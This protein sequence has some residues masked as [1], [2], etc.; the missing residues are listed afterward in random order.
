M[1]ALVA[2]DLDR[3]LI[4]SRRALGAEGRTRALRCV[5]VLD[6]APAAFMTEPCADLLARLDRAAVV[7][8]VT[9][10]MHRQYRRVRLPMPPPRFALAANGGVLYVD[11]VPDAGWAAATRRRLAGG[12]PL[13]QVW[14]Y[15][16][17]VC[18]TEF[19]VKLCN[20]DDLF[21][22]A[23][24]RPH[25]LPSGFVDDVTGWAAER[26][27]RT[28]LQGRKFYLVPERLDKGAAVA[29]VAARAGA[30]HM[31]AAGDS[32]LDVDLLL[33]ADRAIHPAH[34][35]LYERGWSAPHV[36]RTAARGALAGEQIV[37]WLVEAAEGAGRSAG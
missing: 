12:F 34:G 36:A 21:C 23:V 30:S 35:E 9:T 28:S 29:E 10:R 32:F 37:R 24:V 19:T 26:G 27:W 15:A 4:Y 6:E 16:A 7:V 33:A 25:L 20:A 5:E 22:Y 11:G 17:Q 13:Q 18:R 31:F 14:A 2:T 8:P 3:T 1:T